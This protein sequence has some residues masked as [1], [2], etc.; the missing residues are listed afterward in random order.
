[1][2]LLIVLE[3]EQLYKE[4][5]GLV[6]AK[7]LDRRILRLYYN[8]RVIG[9]GTDTMFDTSIPYTEVHVAQR[10]E[11]RFP[12][13]I[14]YFWESP[15][16]VIGCLVRTYQGWNPDDRSFV[17]ALIGN[18]QPGLIHACEHV[19]DR[20][21]AVLAEQDEQFARFNGFSDFERKHRNSSAHVYRL[22]LIGI[23]LAAYDELSAHPGEPS[24]PNYPSGATYLDLQPVIVIARLAQAGSTWHPRRSLFD[25]HLAE[26]EDR[27]ELHDLT[28]YG[29]LL[30]LALAEAQPSFQP[31]ESFYDNFQAFEL[32]YNSAAG[33]PTIVLA[34]ILLAVEDDKSL[35]KP[36]ADS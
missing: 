18:L 2:R 25:T 34:A 16:D 9:M 8:S 36:T 33:V 4:A 11:Q 13:G 27:E 23:G 21:V 19:L 14:R 30:N 12:S 1:L 3:E 32:T 31:G 28:S 24:G 22:V 35:H 29:A 6:F 20:A 7:K 26:F 10:E 17:D 15:I 5:W